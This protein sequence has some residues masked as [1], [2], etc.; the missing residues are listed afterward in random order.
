M[1][2]DFV[3]ELGYLALA[4]RLKRIS[5]AIVHSGRNMYKSLGMDIEPN[6]FLIF[7]LL[8]KHE[9]LSVTEI[10]KKLHF[11]HPSVITL[12]SKMK[13]RGYLQTFT[14]PIDSRKQLF[15]L[16]EKAQTNLPE[17]E[18]VWKAGTKGVADLFPADNNFLDQLET[19]EIQLSQSDFME[20]TLNELQHAE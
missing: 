8:T 1:Q 13:E 5:E 9:Q 6:W 15:E 4:T 19:L 16:T 7:K 2:Y 14:D 20:R 10:A 18:T 11:S 3:N 17:F 12:V